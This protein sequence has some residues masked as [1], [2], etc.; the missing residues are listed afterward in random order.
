[1]PNGTSTTRTFDA[2]DAIS[3]VT[4]GGSGWGWPMLYARGQGDELTGETDF[5]GSATWGYDPAAQVTSATNPSGSY[6]FDAAGDP[7]SV[8]GANASF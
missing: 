3:S 1:M 8:N 2:D 6:G 4:I 7:T 5:A